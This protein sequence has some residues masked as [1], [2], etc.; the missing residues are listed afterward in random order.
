MN[1]DERDIEKGALSEI[2]PKFYT[3]SIS[4]LSELNDYRMY[5]EVWSNKT[6]KE[7]TKRAEIGHAGYLKT[8]ELGEQ[9]ATLIK[10]KKQRKSDEVRFDHFVVANSISYQVEKNIY[11]EQQNYI[12]LGDIKTNTVFNNII[13]ANPRFKTKSLHANSDFHSKKYL[14]EI[15]KLDLAEMD[16]HKDEES[17]KHYCEI[18]TNIDDISNQNQKMLLLQILGKDDVFEKLQL[19]HRANRK[20]IRCLFEN[21]KNIGK[22]SVIPRLCVAWPFQETLVFDFAGIPEEYS[23]ACLLG[24]L[25]NEQVNVVNAPEYQTKDTGWHDGP[26]L[27]SYA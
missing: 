2:L 20:Q 8:L 19:L 16:L 21:T 26:Q 27:D 25:T 24:T 1:I 23:E 5:A 15:I 11:G 12:Q 6:S 14:P 7:Q 13:K 17:N 22:E 4:Y 18:S 3:S 9:N 10:R